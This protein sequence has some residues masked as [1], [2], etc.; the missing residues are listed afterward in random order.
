MHCT[1]RPRYNEHH[2][3]RAISLRQPNFLFVKYIQVV[4]YEIRTHT[5]CL[6][7]TG[8]VVAYKCWGVQNLQVEGQ[9][10]DPADML[11]LWLDSAKDLL[12]PKVFRTN[13]NRKV[14]MLPWS[15]RYTG[16]MVIGDEQGCSS[17]QRFILPSVCSQARHMAL[18]LP[19]C[20]SAAS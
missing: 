15:T 12:V 7:R 16:Q 11:G 9:E 14:T 4:K 13:V 5:M 17:S 19:F 2:P 3:H 10:Y 1:H 18:G 8:G 20:T 6:D